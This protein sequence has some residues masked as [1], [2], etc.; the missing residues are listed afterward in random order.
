[1]WDEA[2]GAVR[3][4]RA[5]RGE[6]GR[7][8]DCRRKHGSGGPK[9]LCWNKSFPPPTG[10]GPPRIARK[11]GKCTFFKRGKASLSAAVQ[12][13]GLHWRRWGGGRARGKGK[14][15][16]AMGH[17]SPVRVTLTKPKSGCGGRVYSR[18]RFRFPRFGTKTKMPLWTT[19]G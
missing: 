1:M 4:R 13:T 8:R 14:V 16:A 11:P 7:F 9:V 19:C 3:T 12:A 15:T 10:S 5:F 6:R 17:R 18:A 2:I